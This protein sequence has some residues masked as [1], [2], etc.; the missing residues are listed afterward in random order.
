MWHRRWILEIDWQVMLRDEG[1]HMAP[2]PMNPLNTEPTS[3]Q[4]WA[5]FG[6]SDY[7]WYKC[8]FWWLVYIILFGDNLW[9]CTKKPT[10]VC[11]ANV[12]FTQSTVLKIKLLNIWF[13]CKTLIHISISFFRIKTLVLSV[14]EIWLY[15]VFCLEILNTCCFEYLS[16]LWPPA[17]FLFH[18]LGWVALRWP[19]WTIYGP[20]GLTKNAIII[21]I[22][23]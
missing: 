16:H 10:L 4:C 11:S 21:I 6:R 18:R 13:W 1:D 22:T 2:T 23:I 15:G 14:Q 20:G 17:E 8:L 9:N 5:V 7:L 3:M 19:N 12:N